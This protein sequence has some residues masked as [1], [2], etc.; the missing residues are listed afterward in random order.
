M[1]LKASAMRG[2]VYLGVYRTHGAPLRAPFASAKLV[3]TVT[4]LHF[5]SKHFE[6]KIHYSALVA[7]HKDVSNDPSSLDRTQACVG[8]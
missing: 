7:L 6:K 1:M 4:S 3:T 5:V 8:A 2:A